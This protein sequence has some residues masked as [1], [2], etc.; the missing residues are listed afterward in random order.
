MGIHSRLLDLAKG[1]EKSNMLAFSKLVIKYVSTRHVICTSYAAGLSKA[2][3]PAW[4][5]A[6]TK[7]RVCMSLTLRDFG[8]RQD[9]RGNSMQVIH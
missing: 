2:M 6:F 3:C 9:C 4:I 5:R 7:S 1:I 8:E